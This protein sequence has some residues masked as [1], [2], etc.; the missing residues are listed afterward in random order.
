MTGSGRPFVAG[1]V[2]AA[3]EGRRFGD[4]KQLHPVARRP[5]VRRVVEA[6]LASCLA[7][8]VVV[9]GHRAN[10]VTAALAGL[11]VETVVSA[12]YRDGLASSLR[13]GLARVDP[14]AAAAL[15]LPADQP[16]LDAATIDRLIAAWHPDG[17]PIVV[18]THRGRRGAPVLFARALFADLARLEGDAGGRQIVARRPGDVVEVELPSARPLRDVD[19]PADLES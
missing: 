12:G 16:W 4:L 6:A 8:V 10:E 2:L 11:A 13:S 18:P 7:Q 1:V 14:R 5:M 17:P 19:T 3:G 9:I 15:F